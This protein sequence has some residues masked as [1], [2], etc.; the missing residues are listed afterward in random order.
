MFDSCWS[1]PPVKVS[2]FRPFLSYME[3]PCA[4]AFRPYFKVRGPR[5]AHSPFYRRVQ[6]AIFDGRFAAF[7]CYVQ[8]CWSW[9]AG[10]STPADPTQIP[11]CSFAAASEKQLWLLELKMKLQGAWI[12]REKKYCG[13][14]IKHGGNGPGPHPVYLLSFQKHLKTHFG[15]IDFFGFSF[16]ENRGQT[17]K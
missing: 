12:I 1:W 2:R 4:S 8:N 17:D 6:R 15:N 9:G 16:F 14:P 10:L 11:G 5:W 13:S 7:R 3:N